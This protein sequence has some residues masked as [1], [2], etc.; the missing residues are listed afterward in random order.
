[1][2]FFFC[3]F[4][5]LFSLSI[6]LLPD[7]FGGDNNDDDDYSSVW[8]LYGHIFQLTI[9]LSIF[10]VI[11]AIANVVVPPVVAAVVA[12]VVVLVLVLVLDCRCRCRCRCRRRSLLCLLTQFCGR[13][14]VYNIVNVRTRRQCI[15]LHHIDV[16][17]IET[18]GLNKK[19]CMQKNVGQTITS[20]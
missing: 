6:L 8:F 12:A 17:N 2:Y 15:S 3:E 18:D 13:P 9:L 16:L 19:I 20:T 11:T 4:S 7:D 5:F 10:S 14:P 1:M